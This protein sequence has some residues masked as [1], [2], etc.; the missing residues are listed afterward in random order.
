M[1]KVLLVLALCASNVALADIQPED[2]FGGILDIIQDQ[3]NKDKNP[4]WDEDYGPG[5]IL[6]DLGDDRIALGRIRLDKDNSIGSFVLPKCKTSPNEL[7][8][9][10]RFRITGADAY[11]RRVRI[12]YQ[13]GDM[14]NVSVDETYESGTAS[15]WYQVDTGSRCVKSIT[16]RGEPVNNGFGFGN[17]NSGGF[18]LDGVTGFSHKPSHLDWDSKPPV[19][20]IKQDPTVLTFI[21]LKAE[22]NGF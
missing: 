5:V 6:K 17:G 15:D 11:V 13:N 18:D 8:S 9:A 10:L 22:T 20:I 14:E 19:I 12:V 3:I 1:K 7:V 2:I 4:G 16:V 21:G